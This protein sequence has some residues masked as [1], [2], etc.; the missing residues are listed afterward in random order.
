[1]SASSE[2]SNHEGEQNELDLE[3]YSQYN[4]SILD[5]TSDPTGTNLSQVFNSA[6]TDRTDSPSQS[7]C[8]PCMGSHM[9]GSDYIDISL[10]SCELTPC[11]SLCSLPQ[12]QQP[13]HST[14]VSTP[15][16]KQPEFYDSFESASE[17][18]SILI[19]QFPMM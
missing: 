13:L 10:S 16:S 15:L 9:H 5:D 2:A 6:P 19:T 17:N 7:L 12:W 14:P 1:M 11:L 18:S 8:F 4:Y 3:C